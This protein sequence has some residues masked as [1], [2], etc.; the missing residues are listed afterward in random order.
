MPSGAIQIKRRTFLALSDTPHRTTTTCRQF[1]QRYTQAF[2]CRNVILGAF[3]L[4]MYVK[5]SCRNNIRTKNERARLLLMK[6]TPIR[7]PNDI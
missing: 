6:L 1:H 2:F 4:R 3:F 5:K 7:S